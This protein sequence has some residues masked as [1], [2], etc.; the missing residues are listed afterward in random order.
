MSSAWPRKTA[1]GEARHRQHARVTSGLL[2]QVGERLGDPRAVVRIGLCAVVDV[3]L[4]VVD[5][6]SPDRPGGVFEQQ[7][8]L[9]LRGGELCH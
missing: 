5:G 7:L 6:R 3:P 1:C 8:A 2:G 4:L 9:L